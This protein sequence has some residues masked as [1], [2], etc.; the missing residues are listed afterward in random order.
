MSHYDR[1]GERGVKNEKERQRNKNEVVANKMFLCC[2]EEI[3]FL[4]LACQNED[5]SCSLLC[6]AYSI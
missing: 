2:S 6:G 3:N 1:G 4:T 5:I